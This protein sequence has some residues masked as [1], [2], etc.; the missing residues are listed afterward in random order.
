MVEGKAHGPLNWQQEAWGRSLQASGL[1]NRVR[2]TQVMLALKINR[3]GCG[4]SW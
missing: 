4:G 1:V 2:F 3:S